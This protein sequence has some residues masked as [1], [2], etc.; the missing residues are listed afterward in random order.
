MAFMPINPLFLLFLGAV[1]FILVDHGIT[2]QKKTLGSFAYGQNL[3]VGITEKDNESLIETIIDRISMKNEAVITYGLCQDQKAFYF[4]YLNKTKPYKCRQLSFFDRSINENIYPQEISA[5]IQEVTIILLPELLEIFLKELSRLDIYIL[6]L[7]I[8]GI[9]DEKLREYKDEFPYNLMETWLNEHFD[10]WKIE[11]LIGM[12]EQQ[13]SQ[14]WTKMNHSNHQLT[15]KNMIHYNK[16]TKM[17]AVEGNGRKLTIRA[18]SIFYEAYLYETPRINKSST[19]FCGDAKECDIP[20]KNMNG[21]T[22]YWRKGCCAGMVIDMFEKIRER[23]D[24]EYTLYLVEDNKWGSIENGTWNGMIK[25]LI[26]NKADIA[27]NVMTFI[28]KRH[29]IVDFSYHFIESSYG[30][31]RVKQ[32]REIFPS[33]QF[34]SP[35]SFSLSMAIFIST[36]LSLLSIS[37]FENLTAFVYTKRYV[38]FQESMAYI[39][40]LTFQRDMGGT[41]PRMWSGRLAALG[42]ASAMTI[43]MSIYTARITANSI[44]QFVESDLKGFQDE[45]FQNPTEDFKFTIVGGIGYAIETY[46]EEHSDESYRRMYKFMS[47]YF[48]NSELEAVKNLL[49]GSLHAFVTDFGTFPIIFQNLITKLGCQK[50]IEF[51]KTSQVGYH[52]MAFP[53]RKNFTYGALISNLILADYERGVIDKMNRGWFFDS[54]CTGSVQVEQFDWMYFSGI[55][56]IVSVAV[57]IGIVF[58]CLEH[59]FVYIFRRCKSTVVAKKRR[60]VGQPVA[61][62]L[63]VGSEEID[64][65]SYGNSF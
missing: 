53:Y 21:K 39:Y 14:N 45:R 50:D 23:L 5:A 19:Y 20:V 51:V 62:E 46:F 60:V 42:Y 43:I 33:W 24:F 11:G 61:P 49:D 12:I 55:L 6:K 4:L 35:L 48:V 47:K 56:V 7:R 65:W 37:S 52:G 8:V 13:N 18:V 36:L 34:L 17:S 26:D 32:R 58:N 40:G 27:L 57:L 2:Y 28:E 16:P 1:S 64:P 54:P 59:C 22:I 9:S 30:I 10:D 44:G 38:L 3:T 29:E 41:N 25:D 15:T 63:Y 31:I